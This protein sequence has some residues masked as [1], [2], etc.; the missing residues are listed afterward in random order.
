MGISPDV[1]VGKEYSGEFPGFVAVTGESVD[2]K[3]A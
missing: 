2:R 3:S 1:G